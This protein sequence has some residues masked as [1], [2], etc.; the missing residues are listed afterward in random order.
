MKRYNNQSDFE[1]MDS[2]RF[3]R[4]KRG[5]AKVGILIIQDDEAQ[6]NLDYFG[7]E[8]AAINAHIILLRP[9]PSASAVFEELIHATQ[10]RKGLMDG[11]YKSR[12]KCEFEAA[13]KLIRCKKS[14]GIT[15]KE[16]A[17]TRKNLMHYYNEYN[18]L[19]GEADV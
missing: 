2:K 9:N 18:K 17:I 6:R 4:I 10:Y 14:Y 16:D 8:A 19:K 5:C 12:L 1:P 11:S 3:K 15:D 13:E 7:N